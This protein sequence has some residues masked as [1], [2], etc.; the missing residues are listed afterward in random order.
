[1]FNCFRLILLVVTIAA[2]PVAQ[3]ARPVVLSPHN[4]MVIDL[5]TALSWVNSESFDTGKLEQI[6]RVAKLA[7]LNTEEAQTL[8]SACAFDST[9]SE[10]LIVLFDAVDDKSEYTHALEILS[11]SA[12]RIKVS[13]ALGL[14]I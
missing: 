12:Y 5:D 3:A 10:A 1:M 9:R 7:K 4:Q 13:N 14:A 11:F 8:A 6:K 2:T